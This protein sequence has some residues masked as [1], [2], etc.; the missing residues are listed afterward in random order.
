MKYAEHDQ[1]YY[2]RITYTAEKIKKEGVI[3][4]IREL[5]GK[6]PLS[7]QTLL[8]LQYDN[9]LLYTYYYDSRLLRYNIHSTGDNDSPLLITVYPDKESLISDYGDI[10]AN[11]EPDS[12]NIY[13]GYTRFIADENIENTGYKR[14]SRDEYDL[15]FVNNDTLPIVITVNSFNGNIEKDRQLMISVIE[16]LE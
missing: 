10:P 15:V 3:P 14:L 16:S 8:D 4:Q 7:Y 6:P 9:W 1:S 5:V 2:D 13:Y 12:C 11:D